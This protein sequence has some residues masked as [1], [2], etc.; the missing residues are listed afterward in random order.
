MDLILVLA[1]VALVRLVPRL[2]LMEDS[3][4]GIHDNLDSDFVYRVLIAKPGR[5][6]D[7]DAVVTELLGGQARWTYPSS[8][9][10]GSFLFW[11]F[12]PFWAYVVEEFWVTI[13]AALGMWLLLRDY[14]PGPRWARGLISISFALLPYYFVYE[15]SVAGQA[16]LTWALLNLWGGKRVGVSLGVCATFPFCSILQTSGAFVAISAGLAW[17][18]A[19]WIQR[20]QPR[21]RSWLLAGGGVFLLGAGYVVS[22]YV[23]IN[24]F[25]FSNFESQRDG[26]ASNV[27]QLDFSKTY[28]LWLD[29][30]YHAESEHEYILIV[31]IL[32]TLRLFF[33]RERA[34]AARLA[35]LI[36]LATAM[37]VSRDL[38]SWPA[39]AEHLPGLRKVNPRF[40]WS[41]P[42]VWYATLGV[43]AQD[44]AKLRLG[45]ALLWVVLIAQ[46]L[47]V[48]YTA[49]QHELNNNYRALSA[50]I[51]GEKSPIWS[52]RNFAA[53]TALAKIEKH[54]GPED[55][56]RF[57]AIGFHPSVLALYGFD[58]ADGYR[59]YF[60]MAYKKRFMELVAPELKHDEAHRN[61][62]E[63]Y[64]SRL[65]VFLRKRSRSIYGDPSRQPRTLSHLELD[66]TALH[67]LGV[68]WLVSILR[69]KGDALAN[70]NFE[71]QFRDGRQG[72]FYY[73]YRVKDE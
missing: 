17:V 43:I 16:L 51:R 30:H 53:R 34:A 1:L 55:R 59:N 27:A 45:K 11:L 48:T 19:L 35:K 5:P 70:L 69:L 66:H 31:S 33:V 61:Y 50:H 13:S 57:L 41:L 72:S 62:V 20:K 2:V 36:V 40:W 32:A 3:Y 58:C 4:I 9:K 49:K 14:I 29:G 28:S 21:A 24:G 68:K 18:G 39:V 12:P 71:G 44:W 23:F 54:I 56:G 37:A 67:E 52:Y 65:Y 22:D 10:F 63:D 42:L 46:F 6:F 38:F 25:L 8:L 26:W 47:R 73:L 60:T 64:G 7:G 15:L